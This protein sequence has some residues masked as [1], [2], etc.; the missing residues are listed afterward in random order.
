MSDDFSCTIEGLDDLEQQLTQMLP[1]AANTAIRR[2]TRLAGDIVVVQAEANA[3]ELTGFLSH[4]MDESARTGDHS[5]TV[6][7]GPIK[8]A[9]YFRAGQGSENRITFKGEEHMA[10]D[11][12]RFAELGT[13]HQPARPFLAPALEEKQDDVITVFMEEMQTEIDKVQK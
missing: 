7:I 1:K 9:G 12:A 8:G 5:I 6:K 10:E 4:H 3:P 13:V 2:A 11:A